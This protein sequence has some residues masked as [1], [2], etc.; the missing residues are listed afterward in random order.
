VPPAFAGFAFIGS[1]AVLVTG[2]NF[3]PFSFASQ[4]FVCFALYR[5]QLYFYTLLGGFQAG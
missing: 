5:V 1:Q 4:T 2:D 3:R